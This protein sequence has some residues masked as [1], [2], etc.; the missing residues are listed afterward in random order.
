MK[1]RSI[2]DT[3]KEGTKLH[4]VNWCFAARCSRVAVLVDYRIQCAGAT[5]YG[6]RIAG[7]NSA[8]QPDNPG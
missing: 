7:V 4:G 6:H 3:S 2:P 5:Y 8:L 1:I